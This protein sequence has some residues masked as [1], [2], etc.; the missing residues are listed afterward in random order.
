MLTELD[1]DSDKILT[2]ILDM[3]TIYTKYLNQANNAK[4]EC[5][6]ICI[7]ALKLKQDFQITNNKKNETIILLKAQ[8]VKFNQYKKMIDILQNSLLTKKNQLQQSI[9]RHTLV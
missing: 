4:K 3:H 8:V 2:M 6:Q 5:N 9:K 7:F 1:K